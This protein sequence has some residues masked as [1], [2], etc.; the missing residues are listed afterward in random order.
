[1][2]LR[3]TLAV[4]AALATLPA[5]A[6]TAAAIPAAAFFENASFSNPLLSPDGK[7]VAIKV[8]AKNGRVRL[9]VTDAASR[10]TKVIA[11]FDDADITQLCEGAARI[12]LQ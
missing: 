5:A 8:A 11:A 7:L 4:I 9:A 1:M 12:F 2:T 3:C 6:Q 10:K